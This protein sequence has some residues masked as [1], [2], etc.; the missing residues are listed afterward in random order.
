VQTAIEINIDE[1]I[2][3]SLKAKKQEFAQILCFYTALALYRQNKLSLGKAAKLAGYSRLDF[4]D[5]LR[6][7]KQ[8]IFD[9]E[10]ELTEEMVDAADVLLE[11]LS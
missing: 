5:K 4:I 3:L 1:S 9:Y 2:L 6:L 8:S 10:T 11:R 7:E